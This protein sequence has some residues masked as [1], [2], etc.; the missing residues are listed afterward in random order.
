LANVAAFWGWV[1]SE[2]SDATG[3][4]FGM[5][6]MLAVAAALFNVLG[7]PYDERPRGVALR[8]AAS[9]VGLAVLTLFPMSVAAL[10]IAAVVVVIRVVVPEIA[11]A[12][13]AVAFD[14]DEVPRPGTVPDVVA[15]ARERRASERSLSVAEPGT[16]SDTALSRANQ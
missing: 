7:S 6:M 5:S 3:V 13:V 2:G 16:C 10:W 11:R 1:F 12:C 4:V 9:V 8:I 14:L 15:K